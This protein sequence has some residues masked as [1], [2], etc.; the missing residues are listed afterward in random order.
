MGKGR[1]GT[2]IRKRESGD[3]KRES[4]D[5]KRESGNGSRET[6]NG[7]NSPGLQSGERENPT[8]P[9][10]APLSRTK[11]KERGEISILFFSI[12]YGDI[13]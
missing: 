7:M 9:S 10:L 4:G 6:G 8:S 11:K 3:R 2:G 12:I 1:R 5:R 13:V